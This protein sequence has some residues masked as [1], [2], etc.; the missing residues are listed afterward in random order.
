M[1]VVPTFVISGVTTVVVN[2]AE[3]HYCCELTAVSDGVLTV[4]IDGALIAATTS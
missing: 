2:R 1:Q 4:V 3:I